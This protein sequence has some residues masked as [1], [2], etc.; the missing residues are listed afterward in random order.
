MSKTISL[1]LKMKIPEVY[2]REIEK[3]MF[4]DWEK[5]EKEGLRWEINEAIASITNN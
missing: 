1:E 2:L 4:E 5:H 3:R